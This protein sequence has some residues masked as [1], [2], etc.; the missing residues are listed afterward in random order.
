MENCRTFISLALKE[1]QVVDH[2]EN[3]WT[4]IFYQ[5]F[6]AVLMDQGKL[7]PQVWQ[8]LAPW[9]QMGGSFQS[10]RQLY[11]SSVAMLVGFFPQERKIRCYFP[12]LNRELFFLENYPGPTTDPIFC[13]LQ[14]HVR[15]LTAV[16]VN[17]L[18]STWETV[19][20]QYQLP[21]L[22]EEKFQQ[23]RP[24]LAEWMQNCLFSMKEYR[25]SWFEKISDFALTLTAKYA[26]IRI[27]LL[28]FV[29][30]LPALDHDLSGREVKR[31]LLESLR[32]MLADSA[33]ALQENKSGEWQALPQWISLAVQLK[34]KFLALIP[35][36]YLA[37]FIRWIIRLMAQR[38][39]AGENIEKAQTSLQQLF[40]SN[41]DVTLDQLGE[42]VISPTEADHYCAEVIKL[43]HGLSSYLPVGAMNPAGILRAHVSLKVS[44]LAFDFRPEA[45]EHVYQ[46]AAPRLRQ[47]LLAAKASQCFINIDAERYQYRDCVFQIYRRVL[48]ETPELADYQQTG[49]V[50]Q[51]YL[52]DAYQ[53]LLA[54]VEL[55]RER[56]LLM[57]IRLVKGAYWDA[58]TIEAQAH[59]FD[60]PEFLNKEETDLMF[61]QLVVKIFDFWPQVQLAL[62]SHNVADHVFAHVLRAAH[63]PHLPPVEHQC[64]HMTY[65]ALSVGLA[66]QQLVVRN[67]LPVGGLLVGMAYLVRRI[68]ENSSQVGILSLIRSHKQNLKY[69]DPLTTHKNRRRIGNLARENTLRIFESEFINVPPILLY[70]PASWGNIQQALETLTGQLPLKMSGRSGSWQ[71]VVSPNDPT[72]VVGEIQLASGEEVQQALDHLTASLVAGLWCKKSFPERALILDSAGDLLLARR[73]GLAALMVLEGGKSI[74]EA[75]AEVDEAIDFCRYYA[76]EAVKLGSISQRDK[77]SSQY[78]ARGVV[79][80]IAPWNFPLAIPTGMMAA[81]LVA[82]SSVAFKSAGPTPLIAQMLVDIFHQVGVPTEVLV[83]LPGSGAVV[84]ELLINSPQVAQIVF[85][86]SKEVGLR[87]AAATSQRWYHHPVLHIDYPVKA[88]TEMGGKNAIIVTANA[89]LDETCAGIIKSAF[90]HGGQKCSACSR[91]LVHHS[92]KDK[93]AQRLQEAVKS[94][95]VGPADSWSTLV[96]PL[97]NLR[98][99]ERLQ[100]AAVAAVLEAQQHGGTVLVDRSQEILPGSAMGPVLIELPAEVACR[101]DSWASKE[102]F[103]PILHLIAFEDFSQAITIFNSTEYALTGGIYSQSQDEIDALIPHLWAGNIYINRPITGARVAIEP[104]GGMKLSGTGPKAG[105]ANYLSAFLVSPKEVEGQE[106]LLSTVGEFTLATH[107]VGE[108]AAPGNSVDNGTIKRICGMLKVI[109]QDYENLF[110]QREKSEKKLLASARNYWADKAL[111]LVRGPVPNR[112]MAGQQSYQD[113]QL[114]LERGLWIVAASVPPMSIFLS[115]V[116]AITLGTGV[117]IVC[118]TKES[119]AWWQRLGRYLHQAKFTPPHL[120][121]CA[122]DNKLLTSFLQHPGLQLIIFDQAP[123][124]IAT[125]LLCSVA[126]PRLLRQILSPHDLPPENDFASYLLQ[127][128]IPRSLAINTV[129]H[130]ASLDAQLVEWGL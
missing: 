43:I 73:L 99:K 118:T 72:L 51:A 14:A 22:Q 10:R 64:L 102:L 15:S 21:N 71:Q 52:Q 104:F 7:R 96:N 9:V 57:P 27:H 80:V 94:L 97:I 26:L 63:Y 120:V 108:L 1:T 53:H 60:A 16:P 127:F 89:E 48:L 13:Q 101:G 125:D 19:T 36:Y 130:G 18:F 25:P 34:S 78:L 2:S 95:L 61:R 39:I 12:H 42:L 40:A 67:Y 115:V 121:I 92:I 54:I 109:L 3:L 88:I 68:M 79:A 82:G 29:A 17:Q 90:G 33:Q 122:G 74:P 126:V 112:W 55:A 119:L 28:K 128:I 124:Q 47:I 66:R 44:A 59:D 58:E 69:T 46:Q 70:Q 30:I 41:R 20:H 56:G 129:R 100:Q 32:R 116:A 81:A 103:G 31:V 5:E 87:I 91:V 113:H 111:K 123:P 37:P 77:G 75:L 114:R 106:S 107:P 62:A 38:F 93:L 45:F 65:E 83:H 11:L 49:I 86:G 98:E 23:L 8:I 4:V 35:A 117:T 24:L 105:G 6:T 110:T 76:R 84:G 50:V 85:T